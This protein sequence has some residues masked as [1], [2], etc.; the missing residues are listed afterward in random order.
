MV[1]RILTLKDLNFSNTSSLEHGHGLPVVFLRLDLNVPIKNNVILDDTRIKAS[2]KT[3]QWLL[4]RN[5]KI[6]ACSHLGRPKG[7]G[8]EQEF[9]LAPVGVRLAECLDIDVL[10]C[11]DYLEDGFAK[12]VQNLKLGQ[13]ILLENLRFHKGE[14]SGDASFAQALAKNAS[15]YVNDAFGTCHRA[16]ASI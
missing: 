10:L 12:I 11:P 9:S 3:I 7:E 8:F 13:M 6:I 16:D 1:N 2:L 4:E 5:V 14:Q 15:Y